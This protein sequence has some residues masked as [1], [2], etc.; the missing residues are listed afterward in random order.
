MISQYPVPFPSLRH[1]IDK[2]IININLLYGI[3]AVVNATFVAFNVFNKLS[4]NF[5]GQFV[6]VGIFLNNP[7][8][9]LH[10]DGFFDVAGNF[11]FK[12]LYPCGQRSLSSS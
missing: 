7:Q 2:I 6:D 11:L 8:E 5:R 12:L 1:Q 9:M 3:L 4:Q 10:I